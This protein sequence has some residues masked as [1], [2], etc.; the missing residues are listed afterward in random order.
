[1]C[2]VHNNGARHSPVE[3][4]GFDRSV[5]LQIRSQVDDGPVS[6]FIPLFVQSLRKAH[7]VA[8]RFRCTGVAGAGDF[9]QPISTTIIFWTSE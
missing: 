6:Y 5:Q 3:L 1:V 2:K 8:L 9:V 7:L 4:L